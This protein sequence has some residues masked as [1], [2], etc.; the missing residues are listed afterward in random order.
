MT[1][2]QESIHDA[3]PKDDTQ[4]L[5]FC[6]G[7]V[8]TG[9]DW[10]EPI[11]KFH[12]PLAVLL[13]AKADTNGRSSCVTA[14]SARAGLRNRLCV[15]VQLRADGILPHRLVLFD[16]RVNAPQQML[17]LRVEFRSTESTS[18]PQASKALPAL[19][20]VRKHQGPRVPRTK[21]KKQPDPERKRPAFPSGG[22]VQPTKAYSRAGCRWLLT[23][24]GANKGF[25]RGEAGRCSKPW[26]CRAQN[27]TV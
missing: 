3:H 19:P 26:L 23:D 18:Y 13:S 10:V 11:S 7:K 21:Q 25:R 9:C 15:T 16:F 27:K 6:R 14:F 2:R 20:D 17:G 4:E 24:H 12:L 8:A 1:K 5:L 22:L